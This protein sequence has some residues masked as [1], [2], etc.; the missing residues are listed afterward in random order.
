MTDEPLIDDCLD[1]WEEWQLANPVRTFDEFAQLRFQNLSEVFIQQIRSKVNLLA[2]IDRHLTPPSTSAKSDLSTPGL[3][4]HRQPSRWS[5]GMEPVPGYRL[6]RLLGRGGSGEAWSATGPG[7]V[8]VAFKFVA[9]DGR[10]AKSEQ[11]AMELMK[12]VRHPNLLSVSGTWELS[13]YFVILTE[14]ADGTLSDVLRKSQ[15]QGLPGIPRADLVRYMQEAANGLDYLNSEQPGKPPIAH[16]DVKPQ[17]LFMMGGSVKV[18]DL[19]LARSVHNIE[20]SHTGHMTLAFASPEFLRDK[21]SIYSDQYSLAVTYY[22]LR[23][24]KLLFDGS[25]AAIMDG[26]LRGEP[27]LSAISDEEQPVLTRALSKE[28]GARWPSC[29]DF[30]EALKASLANPPRSGHPPSSG[31]RMI[32]AKWQSLGGCNSFLGAA[33]ES[34][35]VCPD[36]IGLYAH[37]V[38]GSIHWHPDFGAFETHG[39]IGKTWATMG[40]ENSWLG[41]PSS[42]EQDLWSGTLDFGEPKTEESH[43]LGR[44]SHFA[45]GALLWEPNQGVR[46]YRRESG[47]AGVKYLRVVEQP[48]KS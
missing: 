2:A 6:V 5:E 11:R 16:R 26:H 4:P 36:G 21:T 29:G 14:L 19:G 48:K 12:S 33:T 38:G 10:L 18:G 3:P 34:K 37:F 41:Y 30:A 25:M 43:W 17:N 8:E 23:T 31:T 44:I 20:T 45:K 1:Q 42:D 39:D 7:G 28:P 46:A 22:C 35:G 27:D 13:G 32:D 9:T 47:S 40:W 24:G 15:Q